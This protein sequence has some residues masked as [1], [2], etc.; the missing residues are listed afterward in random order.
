MIEFVMALS[1]TVIISGV[2][3]ATI[4]QVITGSSRTNNHMIVI[5][6]V[7]EAGFE[8]SRDVQ[9]AQV[10]TLAEEA[11][12][13]PDGTR[14]PLELEWTDWEGVSNT[15][16]YE[17]VDAELLRRHDVDGVGGDW[18]RIAQYINTDPAMTNCAI[19]AGKLIFKVTA[20][21]GNGSEEE[22]ETRVYEIMPRPSWQ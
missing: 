4:F 22:S 20:T 17:I 10:V 13:D 6:Q 7:Q 2:I 11:S 21:L 12:D 9:Q 18:A 8:V 14:F 3:T 16:T 19:D 15:V 5:R 1:I